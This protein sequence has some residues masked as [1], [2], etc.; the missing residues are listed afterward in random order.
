[1]R[2]RKIALLCTILIL[3]AAFLLFISLRNNV[4]PNPEYNGERIYGEDQ[5]TLEFTAMNGE[6]THTLFPKSGDILHCTWRIERGDVDVVIS[7]DGAKVYQGNRIDT[8]DFKLVIPRDGDCMISVKGKHAAG[9]M[10]IVNRQAE[11]IPPVS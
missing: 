2:N 1:M 11:S 3:A 6:Q 5:F 4:Y 7:M 8:A 9:R 10:E